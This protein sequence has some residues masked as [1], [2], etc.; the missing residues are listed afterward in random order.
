VVLGGGPGHEL[1]GFRA[2]GERGFRKC[3]AEDAQRIVQRGGGRRA[4]E[5][6]DSDRGAAG[7]I[8]LDVDLLQDL[9]DRRLVGGTGIGSQPAGVFGI[10]ADLRLR[11]GRGQQTQCRGGGDVLQRV[12]GGHRRFLRRRPGV[13][14]IHQGLDV[15][16]IL[17][18]RPGDKLAGFG[19]QQEA[20]AW[21]GL[22]QQ[23]ERVA[24][25]GGRS[26]LFQHVH[27][28]R[29]AP[30]ASALDVQFGHHGLDPLVIR[31]AGK[32]GEP[33]RIGRVGGERR[34]GHGGLQHGRRGRGGDPLQRVHGDLGRLFRRGGR[35]QLGD[36]RF[37]PLV[38]L[39][40][41]PGHKLI[42]FRAHGERGF[43]KRGA[44]D[45]QGVRQRG[46][47]RRAFE[48]VDG[49][50]GAAGGVALD[51]DLLQDLLDRRLVGGTRV[52]SQPAGVF[53][54]GADLRLGHR[55]GQQTQRRGGG[56]VFQRIHG[57]FGR[58]LRRRSG[59]QLVDQGLDAFV[60]LGRGPG[61]ELARFR[62]HQDA[63][64]GKG[65]R[66]QA[67]GVAH[68]R[69]GNLLLQLVH[70]DR[71]LAA[72]VALDVDLRQDRLDH[73]VFRGAAGGGEPLRVGG[74][75]GEGRPRHGGLQHGDR[76]G[77]G[78]RLQRVQRD[79]GG[80]FG[81]RRRVQPID[82]G[83]D[84]LVVFGRGPSDE[85]AGVGAQGEVGFRERRAEHAQGVQHR[86]RRRLVFQLVHGDRRLGR[87]CAFDVDLL[88][89]GLQHLMVARLGDGHDLAVVSAG[90]DFRGG[91]RRSQDGEGCRRRD[92][93][94]R[95][96]LGR[97]L[98]GRHFLLGHLFDRRADRLLI[99]RRGPGRQAAGLGIHGQTGRRDEAG[100]HLQDGLRVGLAARIN[101]QARFVLVFRS[102]LQL[103]DGLGDHG[104]VRLAG[105]HQDAFGHR[106]R[107]D[108][109]VG[110][111]LLQQGDRHRGVDF[112]QRIRLELGLEIARRSAAAQLLQG[113]FDLLVVLRPG[114]DQD[115]SRFGVDHELGIGKQGGYERRNRRRVGHG[116]R[117]GHQLQLLGLR[118]VLLQLLDQLG[119]LEL[120]AG[121]GPD[122]HRSGV[123]ATEQLQPRHFGLQR[124]QDG[125]E[126]SLLGRR[127]RIHGQL[128]R[129]FGRRA[130][131]ELLD[132]L[133]DGLV[134]GRRRHRDQPLVFRVRR[135]LCRRNHFLED[136][137]QTLG[138]F[139]HQGM[140]AN[141]RTGV[142]RQA[143][144]QLLQRGADQL[145]VGG[146]GQ[147]D[148]VTALGIQRQ[149][150]VG[151][152]FLQQGQ[153]GFGID[154]DQPVNLQLRCI[155]RR[156]ALAEPFQGAAHDL[157]L[158]LCRPDD[159]V[160][161][162]AV[163]RK[164]GIGDQW[165]QRG[166]QRTRCGGVGEAKQRIG[167]EP[168]LLVRGRLGFQRL[169]GF[170]QRGLILGRR[171]DEQTFGRR[172]EHELGLGIAG[173][174][175]LQQTG[176]IRRLDRVRGQFRFALGRRG[177]LELLESRLDRG[178]T[179]RRSQH[180]QAFVVRIDGDFRL[181]VD[182]GQQFQY[183]GRRR[184]L[185][186]VETQ[187]GRLRIGRVRPQF[188][189]RGFDSFMIGCRG[190]HDQPLLRGVRR[191]L[192]Q[193]DQLLEDRLR[194]GRIGPA[195]R[196]RFHGAVVLGRLGQPQL[197]QRGLDPLLLLR[198]AVDDQP[199]G[200]CIGRDLG[201]RHHGLEL[202]HRGLGARG[203]AGADLVD[204]EL[205]L[206][207]GCRLGLQLFDLDLQ[208]RMI[209]RRGPDQQPLGR[210]VE[211]DLRLGIARLQSLH[212]S[213]G[214][215][216]FQ[217]V[218]R[219]FR[220]ALGRLFLL[221]LLESGLD[222]RLAGRRRHHHQPR[223]VFVD[224]DLRLRGDLG[225]EVEDVGRRLQLEGIEPQ[226][227]RQRIGR[228]RAQFVQRGL[229]SF[230][231]G[232]RGQRV[233]PLLCGVRCELGQWDQLLEERLG[234]GQIGPVQ[235]V[236]FHGAAVLRGLLQPQF[237]QGRFDQLLL[238]R[239]AIH[240]Q[241][242]GARVERDLCFRY[243]RLDLSNQGLACRV[244]SGGAD[245]IRL[246][247][248]LV[249]IRSAA[250]RLDLLERRP[251]GLLVR[252]LGQR[253]QAPRPR[254]VAELRVGNQL[255]EHGQQVRGI[256]PRQPVQ[257]QLGRGQG[258]AG[259]SPAQFAHRGLDRL[260]LRRR[261]PDD[262][263][264]PVFL[265]RHGRL[266][267][268]RF[269]R[270]D[271]FRPRLR[272][273]RVQPV[274][275]D[276]P[277][278]LRGGRR[279][280]LVQ[281]RLDH[282]VLRRRRVGVQL[283]QVRIVDQLGRRDELLQ[284]GQQ[285]VRVRLVD[286]IDLQLFGLGLGR[287]RCRWL[288]LRFRK[289]FDHL[290]DVAHDARPIGD[291]QLLRR[292]NREE[293]VIGPQQRRHG[294]GHG[295]RVAAAQRKF[296]RHQFVL[297]PL[298]DF[299]RRDFGDQPFRKLARQVDQGQHAFAADERVAFGQQHAVQQIERLRHRI[300]AVIRIVEGA[301]RRGVQDERQVGL[302]RK[303]LQ[304]IRPALVA[305][306]KLQPLLRRL[307][308]RLGGLVVGFDGRPR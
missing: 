266:G 217:R 233:Q 96:R 136:V 286:G 172:V 196:I 262:H 49:D 284:D 68:R 140:K 187:L 194:G 269:E 234:G 238:C 216:G 278:A 237:L 231:I 260:V 296:D 19:A 211:H 71:R 254:V 180:H 161:D 25:R 304:H 126:A 77:G 235:R 182:F 207:F 168:R 24:H 33:L 159:Q 252:R 160:F 151:S 166:D 150:S 62:A 169:D 51:V 287:H 148:Q 218:G 209:F 171:P 27:G 306:G 112:R 270:L 181:R 105:P 103:L 115:P 224:R 197:V 93:L 193:R 97:R 22:R 175:Q 275:V 32:D 72:G 75:R 199:A 12:H 109:G 54:I 122:G 291:E 288:R 82:Q 215:G 99:V 64:A 17:G 162:F 11:H 39:G 208:Q 18:G 272:R 255:F 230:V 202:R 69:I 95:V 170:R 300:V 276:T 274:H 98:C 173:L 8:T 165:L 259:E 74:V 178:L 198:R 138:R 41:G 55:R 119:D 134:I 34:L 142:A 251:D 121:P 56:D 240:D 1:V 53:G 108:L 293:F 246:E 277:L 179:V 222:G 28:D 294:G 120:L 141:G 16:L 88:Q 70:D 78:D 81:G 244:G 83:L 123:V 29:R 35:V 302:F 107:D 20:G 2:H 130:G 282:G 102:R 164:A 59:V 131:L 273:R 177:L 267:N 205:R 14:T 76:A 4:F 47:D 106:V 220:F 147:S 37:D 117:V 204:L 248:R 92:V 129:F 174:Q 212:Q 79:L 257:F 118:H 258:I 80:M 30:G 5:L 127:D 155:L 206:L 73:F 3:R 183:F 280:N 36:E 111:L 124:R 113:G 15:L 297:A 295:R 60:I 289:G 26:L 158:L 40:G 9:L 228:V 185:E 261:G 157:V 31:R 188:F 236:R 44:E 153:R 133:L 146:N 241:A 268:D 104:L 247:V 176:R 303:P 63:G 65:L 132:N 61:D 45:G 292:G 263:R 154:L 67:D 23:A 87:G 163:D 203:G 125:L 301:R 239:R 85:F 137:Q 66:Q 249:R 285:R 10:G 152:Q 242:A 308:L 156:R 226:L 201:L 245:F 214:R 253:N 279:A 281:D 91:H 101:H 210:R 13:Q 7:G 48:L 200:P 43:W 213:R 149:L 250:A 100:E 225:E 90:R 271:Q 232:R 21:E 227:R 219:Q 139:S 143:G 50:G 42:G 38:V 46:R 305:E 114:P 265:Q 184:L 89:D 110:Q 57:G 86:R 128:A 221:E 145:L 195:Q 191:E 186:R 223:V 283:V 229:D 192:G 290:L 307:R 52:C 58:F 84:A 144:L 135:Q 6:V 243:Q 298:L 189:Q 167:F 116:T 264:R 94:Q 256:H 299:L 190:H